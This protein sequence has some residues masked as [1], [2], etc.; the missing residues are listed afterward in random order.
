MNNVIPFPVPEKSYCLVFMVPRNDPVKINK[1]IYDDIDIQ[2]S[3]GFGRAV[4]YAS[5]KQ[6]AIEKLKN[7]IQS[8]FFV[9]ESDFD[10]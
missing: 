9:K 5:S 3:N 2:I 6:E 8:C 7:T 1:T 4:V 10:Y